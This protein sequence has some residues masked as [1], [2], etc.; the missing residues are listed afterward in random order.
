MV[1]IPLIIFG[2]VLVATVSIGDFLTN[3]L[4]KKMSDVELTRNYSK[5][6]KPVVAFFITAAAF[7]VI[8]L[9]LSPSGANVLQ[10]SIATGGGPYYMIGGSLGLVGL[11]TGTEFLTQRLERTQVAKFRVE[12]LLTALDSKIT[13]ISGEISEIS[14]SASS[15]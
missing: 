14:T 3:S 10:T 11:L 5:I 1:Y 6:L 8:M 15:I 9:G 12:E 7:I 2:V 4:M 13:I